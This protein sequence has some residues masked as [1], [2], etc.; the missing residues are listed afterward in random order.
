MVNETLKYFRFNTLLQQQGWISP[1]YVGVNDAGVVQYLSELPPEEATA[2]E[3][4]SGHVVPGFQNAHSHAF[5]YAMAGQTEKHLPGREDDFWSWRE[6]M[7]MCALAINPEQLEAVAAML[8][9]EMLRYGYT[10]VA[11]FHYLHHDQDG[12]PYTNR[13]EM[14]ERLIAAAKTAG[15]KITL[16]PVFYKQGGFGKPAAPKQRRFILQ[17][18]DEY[19]ALLEASSQLVKQHQHACLGFGVHSL[20]AVSADEIFKTFEFGPKDLPFHLHAAEQLTEVS[21]SIGFLKQR[22]VEWLLDHLPV[23]ERFHIV[24]CTHLSDDEVI[25]LA[26]SRAHV[27]LCPATEGNLGDGVFRLTEFST[28]Y[29]NWCIGSDSQINLNPLEDLRWLDY[30]QR[31]LRH[32]RNTFSDGATELMN[33]LICGGRSAMG[34]T[35]NNFFEINLPFDAVVYNAHTPLLCGK[36]DHLLSKILYTS[37]ASA[38]TGTIVN[39]KWIIKNQ[40]HPNGLAIRTAYDH[41][42]SQL[43]R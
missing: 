28:H 36:K 13:A 18:T 15:I 20:R 34:F 4:V 27:V 6:A 30:G 12:T 3:S 24:H 26:N 5:Q 40:F 23:N 41:A 25:Q 19:F 22:P 35:T 33:K 1:A 32:K 9:A 7:Y 29:G 43:G 17:S 2:I 16:I 21:D 39:G 38:I 42:I 31:L 10:H 14:G 37:D 11:E 8:Y